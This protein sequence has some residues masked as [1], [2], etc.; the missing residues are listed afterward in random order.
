MNNMDKISNKI[1]EIIWT[2]ESDTKDF[3][4]ELNIIEKKINYEDIPL[5]I[6]LFF[7]DVLNGSDLIGDLKEKKDMLGSSFLGEK[8]ISELM[9]IGDIANDNAVNFQRIYFKDK[10]FENYLKTNSIDKDAKFN[11]LY[12][13]T[14]DYY[15]KIG[16]LVEFLELLDY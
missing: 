6:R 16:E 3:R 8:F 14:F 12:K 1:E 7:D 15:H 13:I 10:E 2:C 11:Y 9:R 4:K 5:N